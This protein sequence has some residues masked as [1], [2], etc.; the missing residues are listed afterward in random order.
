[1]TAFIRDRFTW[2][3]YLMLAYF[4][5]MISTLGPLMPFLRAELNLSYSVA[6]MHLSAFALG[7]II[8]GLTGNRVAARWGRRAVLWGGA[9]GMA[10][11]AVFLML[12]RQPEFSIPGAFVMGVIGSYTV[13]II[14][15]SLA[16]RHGERRAIALTESNVAAS[17]AASFA[18]L[19]VGLGES[20]GVTWR[21]SLLAG[22]GWLVVLGV[23]FFRR[24]PLP[25]SQPPPQSGK[26]RPLPRRFWAYWLVILL[27]VSLEWCLG[28]WGADFLEKSV[29][30]EKVTAAT[31][32]SVFFVA[33][34]IGRVI[35]SRLTRN[36]D[37]RRLLVYAVAVVCLGFPI[38]WLSPI[39]VL[40]VIGL[41]VA[42]LGIANM[43]PMTI[44]VATSIDPAQSNLASARMS[45]ASGIAIFASP[46]LL[47]SF[48]D[49]VGIFNA[50]GVAAGLLIAAAIIVVAERKFTPAAVS[51][52][53]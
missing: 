16:D 19:L 38:F 1:M 18:P 21:L 43:F 42:G 36:V 12:A 20:S 33:M 50:F 46:Q 32:M 52:G 15:A 22:I 45:L 44:S 30:L 51:S 10:V 17:I 39:P 35:G 14:P 6:A 11:G 53:R 37:S 49:Q 34:I 47:A 28:F 40:N 26:A 27:S 2:L 13:I 41:F 7:M 29:G 25:A 24:T 23:F 8:A 48:A 5:Y 3:A 31:L 9:V 4:A